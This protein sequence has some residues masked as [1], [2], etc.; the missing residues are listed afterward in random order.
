MLDADAQVHCVSALQVAVVDEWMHKM[1][2]H[3]RDAKS[4]DAQDNCASA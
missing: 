2:A 4:A 1:I 3:L